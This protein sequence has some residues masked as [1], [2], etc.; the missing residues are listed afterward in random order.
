MYRQG[1]HYL[2]PLASVAVPAALLPRFRSFA[3]RQG[4]SLAMDPADRRYLIDYYREDVGKLAS[5]VNRDLS[6]WLH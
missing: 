2:V 1:W 3:F 4:K 6:A 5:L